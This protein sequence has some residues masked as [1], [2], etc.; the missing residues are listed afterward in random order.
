M[1]ALFI[2]G[3]GTISTS[4]TRL[5]AQKGWDLTL[6][7]RGHHSD[8]VPEGVHTM[9]CDVH[10]ETEAAEKL[11]N[12]HFDVVADFIAFSVQD[13]ERDIRLFSGKT[14]QF[15]FISSASAYQKPQCNPVI[16]ESTP[17]CNPYWEYS[18][19]K[20]ACEERLMDAFRKEGFP[21]TIVRPSHTYCEKGIPLALHGT[22][23]SWTVVDRIRKGKKI[24]IPGDGTT[25]WT[26]TH[27]RDFAIG[28]EGL[29]GNVHAIGQTYHITG[30][31]NLTWNQIHEIIAKAVGQPLKPVYIASETL[32]E[33]CDDYRGA[34]LGDKSN[35][36][37]FDN[38]KIKQQ[39][40][41]FRTRIR[42]SEGVREAVAFIDAHPELQIIDEA[43]NTWCDEVISQ[44]E[45]AVSQMPRY[46]A[47]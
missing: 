12:R 16:T 35:S 28:F 8:E 29:M 32:A 10:N 15:F 21:V 14:D 18:R 41:A 24:I 45:K 39:V 6:L 22:L 2:G 25:F 23:G 7:N 4:I 43:F 33:L 19:N 27:S 26:L 38:S 36:V 11:K 47:D 42:F 46:S 17:L 34:L 37:S 20:Q 1:K 13:V 30:D 3:T 9:I 31:E 44:Y 5:C 40:P